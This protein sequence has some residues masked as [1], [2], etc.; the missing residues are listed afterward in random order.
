MNPK[1]VKLLPIL[2]F[3]IILTLGILLIPVVSDYTNHALA[4]QAA[5][6]V[7][8]WFL[9]HL[10]SALSFGTGI[11]ATYSITTHL[12]NHQ[13]KIKGT[14]ILWLATIGGIL[15]AIGLGTDGI[16][17][18]ATVSGGGQAIDFF[19][20][21]AVYVPP[22]FIAASLLFG[23][24]LIVQVISLIKVRLIDGILKVIVPVAA[25]IFIGA[26]AIP[27]G[28]GLYL[29]ALG[30]LLVYLPIGIQMYRYY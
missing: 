13:T 4:E 19:D 10:I 11:L 7:L 27:S 25:M 12:E 30:A 1:N 18:L 26:P 22:I 28:W 20:G 14:I 5:G 23:I 29:V 21:S 2:L 24:A 16:G 8:R 6:H 9:G 15:Y 17:P 3:P